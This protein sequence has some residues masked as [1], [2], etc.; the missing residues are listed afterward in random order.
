MGSIQ[1]DVELDV[2]VDRAWSALR[3][4]GLAHKLFAGVL[5]EGE[6]E[7]GIRTVTFAD[8]LQVR[9][10]I[11]DVNEDRRRVAYAVIE[12][13]PMIHHNASMQIIGIGQPNRCRFVWIADFLPDEFGETMLPLI[14]AGTEALK[15]NLEGGAFW[16]E[17]E[18]AEAPAT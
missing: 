7:G 8:G 18:P 5:T 4:V 11:V 1:H 13:T 12:G 2:S 3:Q 14:I 15:A 9:E 16:N 17:V 6:L 10:R